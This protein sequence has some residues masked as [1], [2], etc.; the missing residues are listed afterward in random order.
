MKAKHTFSLISCPWIW[1]TTKDF[2]TEYV[3]LKTLFE[4]AEDYI[5]ITS[6]SELITWCIHT[7]IL[8]IVFTSC[9]RDEYL[10][11]MNTNTLD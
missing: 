11:E 8:A 7:L 2:K 10:Y 1:V 9:N 3:G 4:N 6:E 5:E